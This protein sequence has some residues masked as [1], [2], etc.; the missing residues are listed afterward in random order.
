MNAVA[1]AA[2][3]SLSTLFNYFPS[4]TQLLFADY[5]D[6][7][8]G[9]VEA[10]RARGEQTPTEAAIAW[11]AARRA[12]HPTTPEG[13]AWRETLRRIVDAD[14]ALRAAEW[15]TFAPGHETLIE[16]YAAEL[17]DDA[18]DIRPQSIAAVEQALRLRAARYLYEAD[19][20]DQFERI[21]R[22]VDECVRA[23]TEA[24][25]KIPPP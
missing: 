8:D 6:A 5:N 18:D 10:I 24:V 9:F 23:A 25:S 1:E 15:E 22:Y 14:P 3:V 16:A 7:V 21:G 13:K 11:N 17:G 20:P 12:S 4:K 19:R 2:D